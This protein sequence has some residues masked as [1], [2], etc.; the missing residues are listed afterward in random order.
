MIVLV[1]GI[2]A[3]EK[4]LPV[5]FIEGF[6]EQVVHVF[7]LRSEFSFIFGNVRGIGEIVLAGV[8]GVA[9]TMAEQVLNKDEFP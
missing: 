8:S 2:G 4:S 6:S 5:F 3:S 1:F 9:S 7:A